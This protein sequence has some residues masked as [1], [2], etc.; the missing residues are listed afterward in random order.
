MSEPRTA[1][2]RALIRATYG[3]RSRPREDF[4]ALRDAI[5]TI[6]AEAAEL[7]GG[8]D[9]ERLATAIHSGEREMDPMDRPFCQTCLSEAKR[10]LAALPS[11]DVA[12]HAELL[13]PD[14]LASIQSEFDDAPSVEVRRIRTPEGL[15]LVIGPFADYRHSVVIP[16]GQDE[17]PRTGGHSS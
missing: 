2:G 17:T 3:G 13:T 10:Y 6:E 7:A 11:A 16:A 1:A 8:L 4:E 5:L 15:V 14:F 12:V 9:A